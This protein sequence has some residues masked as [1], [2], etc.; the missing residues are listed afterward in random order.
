MS[1]EVSSTNDICLKDNDDF[2]PSAEELENYYNMLENGTILELEWQCPGR[3][4]PSPDCSSSGSKEQT[5]STDITETQEPLKSNDFDFSD[6]VA[7]PQMRV[8]SQNSTPKSVKKITANF[9][10]VMEALKK[11]NAE[12]SS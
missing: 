5:N 6:D 9:A 11:K 1:S 7:Q 8:R 3:R 10:G 4:P 12:G 2:Y